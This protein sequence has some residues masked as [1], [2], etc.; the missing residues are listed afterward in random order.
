VGDEPPASWAKV[1]QGCVVRLRKLLGPSAVETTPQGYRLRVPADSMDSLRFE[2]LLARGREVL[3][4]GEPDR[5]EY[6][7]GEALALWRARRSLSW[8]SG[9]RGAWRLVAWRSTGSTPR[10]CGWKPP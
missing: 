5:A 7:L 10:S 9:T 8:R 4:L 6:L 2:R 1:V 3:T